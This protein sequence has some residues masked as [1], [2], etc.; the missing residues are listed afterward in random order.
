VR[1]LLD[2]NSCVYLMNRTRPKLEE[3]VVRH[4][5]DDFA[6]SIITAAELT[7]GIEKSQHR[8]RNAEKLARLRSEFITVAFDEDAVAHYGR[9]RADLERRGT[10]I[11]PLDQLIAAH[12]LSLDLTLITNNVREFERV[13][14]LRF[15]NWA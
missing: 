15:E 1:F 10:P 2:T 9:I 6:I 11:G 5:A 8:Q 4:D 3:R 13:R 7:Y 12:A 14:G